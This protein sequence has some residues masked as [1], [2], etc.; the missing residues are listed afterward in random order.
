VE[1][2][3]LEWDGD[4]GL[5]ANWDMYYTDSYIAQLQKQSKNVIDLE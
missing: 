1:G 3:D 2:D 4:D 5:L